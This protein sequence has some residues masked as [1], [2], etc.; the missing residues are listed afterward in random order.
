[1]EQNRIPIIYQDHHLLIVNK[2]AGLVVHPTYKHT[3]GTLWNLLVL[4][5]ARQGSDGWSPPD[6]PDEPG[7][8]YAP[9]EIRLMLREQRLA[10]TRQEEGWLERPV[11]LH[12][13]DKDTSGVLALARTSLACRH[14]ARQ[15]NEHTIVKTYLAVARRAAPAWA[16]PR[17]PLTVT[18]LR[19]QEH[20]EQL[21]LLFDQ[22]GI[23]PALVIQNDRHAEQLSLPFDQPASEQ[24]EQFFQPLAFA[25]YQ[26]ASLLL[27]GP[28][29]RDPGDRRRCIVGPD[30]QEART[31]VHVLAAWDEYVLVAV[32]PVTG[33]THQIRAHLAAAGYS[34]VGDPTYA[35]PAE[36]GSPAAALARQFLHAHSLTLR[37]SPVNPPRTFVAPL[38]A[39]LAAWLRMYFPA[40][41]EMVASM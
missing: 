41:L 1:M 20:E 2:P 6:L 13:L 3:E 37:G 5:L 18:L 7:W 9:Q 12:R 24:S 8:E 17:V 38:P 31:R 22:T 16:Q 19:E 35:P 34:L 25:A 21:L 36:P 28:L 10:K 32:Q 29:Q 23:R 39:D 33:R 30:G 40:G 11:L 14:I 27:D 26:G 15:F 4:D